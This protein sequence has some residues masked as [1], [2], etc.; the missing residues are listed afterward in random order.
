MSQMN[1]AT[2]EMKTSCVNFNLKLEV[3]KVGREGRVISLKD[4]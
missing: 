2:G 4:I 1:E 3:S